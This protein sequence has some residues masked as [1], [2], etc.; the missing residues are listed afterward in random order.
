M[1]KAPVSESPLGSLVTIKQGYTFSRSYQGNAE[2]KWMYVKVA[3]LNSLG[4]KKYV[5]RTKNYVDD[6]VLEKI[7]ATP[8]PANS[9]VFPRVGAALKLNNKLLLTED[10]VTDDNVIVITVTDEEKCYFEYL[11]Y[12]FEFQDLGRFCNSGAVPV[13]SGKNLKKELVPLPLIDEQRKISRILSEWDNAIE[14]TEALI[15]AKEKQFEWLCTNLLSK[16]KK[17]FGFTGKSIPTAFGSIF[18]LFKKVN[19]SCA[20]YEV[21]SVTKDGIVSQSEYF[22]KEVASKDKSKYLI[23]DKYTLVMSG[24]NFWMGAIDFQTIRDT[25]IV[26]PAYKT[27]KLNEGPYNRDYLRFFIRSHYM[28]KILLDSSIQGASIVR[29]NLDMEWLSNSL[30]G[31]PNLEEQNDIANILSLAEKEIDGLKLLAEKYRIQ[32]RGLMQ[33]LLTGAWQVSSTQSV[34]EGELREAI[35]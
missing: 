11:Y 17:S 22:N 9:I 18:S 20:D 14:K 7:K 6:D 10:C 4:N 35:A 21:L 30:I 15:A 24:L 31:L 2:G 25:G 34:A 32:K 12:W 8:F 26:S 29:R 5:Y 28:T 1:S 33:K 23:V 19:T 3:D 27:F 13:I 16:R